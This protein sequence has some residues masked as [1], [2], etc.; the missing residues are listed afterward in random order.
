MLHRFSWNLS[1]RSAE[2][3]VFSCPQCTKTQVGTS[4]DRRTCCAERRMLLGRTGSLSEI[5]GRDLDARGIHG[6]RHAASGNRNHGYHAEAVEIL[7]D[8]RRSAFARSWSSSNFTIPPR[9]IAQGN[10]VGTSYRSAIYFTTDEQ[11][12]VTEDTIADVDV[13]RPVA[14]QENAVTEVAPAGDFWEA[15][16]EHR[17]YPAKPWRLH[18]PFHPPRLDAAEAQGQ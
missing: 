9:A 14:R 5:P 7:F 16:P 3:P 8:P 15:E 18:L 4:H 11:R 13:I 12:R 2:S 17:D 6:R 10:D 1:F